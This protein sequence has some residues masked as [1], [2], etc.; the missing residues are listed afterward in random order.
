MPDQKQPTDQSARPPKQLQKWRTEAPPH[1]RSV[2]DKCNSSGKRTKKFMTQTIAHFDS[3]IATLLEGG[4]AISWQSQILYNRK[5]G[6]TKSDLEV[7]IVKPEH[8][9]QHRS[10]TITP[11]A[12][13]SSS[14]SPT[15]ATGVTV[16]QQSC[17][18]LEAIASSEESTASSSNR[19]RG[20]Q[21]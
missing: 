11:V 18:P 4:D 2:A 10:P 15:G 14:S 21:H 13:S 7:V 20:Q 3:H 16:L 19:K 8:H 9:H 5:A 6:T 1:P 17:S 12:V